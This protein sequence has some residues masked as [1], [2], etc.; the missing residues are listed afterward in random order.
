MSSFEL[1]KEIGWNEYRVKFT[2]K[3]LK[4][5]S[6]KELVK[7]KE[8]ITEAEYNIKSG[9]ALDVNDEIENAFFR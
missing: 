1:A 8:N 6:L 3:D 9:Q 4:N 5:T 7:L 2:L